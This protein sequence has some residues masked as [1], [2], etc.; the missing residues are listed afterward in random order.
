[1]RL[2]LCSEAAPDAS[3]D[4]LIAA[5]ARRGFLALELRAG[6][7]HGVA[8]GE[9]A[10]SGATAMKLAEAGLVLTGFRTAGVTEVAGLARL[11]TV[12]STPLLIDDQG[13][14]AERIDR[15]K[16]LATAGATVAVVVRGADALRDAIIVRSAGL[17]LAWDADP[18]LGRLGPMTD[19]LLEQCRAELGHVRLIGGGPEADRQHGRGIGQMMCSL[20]L[21][22][23]HGNLIL[24]P[25]STRFRVLWD[26]WLGRR[27]GWGCGSAASESSP[28][29][30]TRLS[31]PGGVR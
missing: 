14:L 1:M 18:G 3:L 17:A 8:P 27:R 30:L 31:P 20:A 21:A 10:R 22:A 24:A 11:S 26:G 5:A 6:D 4:E 28:A 16:A 23:F 9:A 15:A 29:P 13:E 2:G 19:E 25:S 12:L 7:A